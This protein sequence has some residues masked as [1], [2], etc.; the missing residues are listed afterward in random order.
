MESTVSNLSTSNGIIDSTLPSVMLHRLSLYNFKNYVSA[1]LSFSAPVVCFLGSNGSGKTNLLD[2]IHY[3][4][5]CK[6]YFNAADS[7]NIRVGE[8]QAGINGEWMRGESA[9]AIVC[10]LRKGQ[11]KVF[12]RNHKEY[13]RLADH[14]GLLPA[15]IITPYDAELI[16]EGSEVRRRFMDTTLSQ[17]SR[18]ALDV[19]LN[20]NQ[21]LLQRNNLLKQMAKNGKL[22]TELLEPWD[23]QLVHLGEQIYE[24]RK[25]FLS[26]FVPVF[27]EVYAY[28]TE[29]REQPEIIYSTDRE[30]APLED[31]LRMHQQRDFMLER[32]TCGPHKDELE[33]QLNGLTLKKFASQGQQKSFLIALKLAQA[34]YLRAALNMHPVILLD[35][36]YDKVDERRVTRLLQ[37]LKEFHPGQ[38]FITDTDVQRIPSILK[39][40]ETPCEVWQ[41]EQASVT[42]LEA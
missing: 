15:V 18:S 2:A 36:L 26:A 25:K 6:S 27:N 13:D 21:A 22:I 34:T 16:H 3:L 14:V 24:E 12:K 1:E 29:G 17:Q 8:D 7:Q 32:T 11:R 40:M 39:K 42:Q 9:E 30:K 41:V 10:G 37:W 33:F 19:L 20:Y 5:L 31:L 38:V 35:D 28:I 23:A 4:S